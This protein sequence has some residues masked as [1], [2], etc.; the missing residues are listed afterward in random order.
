V[1]VDSL[2]DG[3]WLV[4]VDGERKGYVLAT[5]LHD[6]PSSSKDQVK[7]RSGVKHDLVASW[8]FQGAVGSVSSLVPQN[9]VLTL[10]PDGKFKFW[11]LILKEGFAGRELIFTTYD[12]G[13]WRVRGSVRTLSGEEVEALCFESKGFIRA[14]LGAE[15]FAFGLDKEEGELLGLRLMAVSGNSVSVFNVIAEFDTEVV[16]LLRRNGI[17]VR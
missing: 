14:R 16:P 8:A 15:C 3:W 9:T 10:D 6:E 2:S 17:L 4:Y 11:G 7:L 1:S 12:E 13:Q 5:L